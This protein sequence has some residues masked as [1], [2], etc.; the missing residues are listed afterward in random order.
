MK[1]LD[2]SPSATLTLRDEEQEI[3]FSEGEIEDDWY[4][5]ENRIL[6]ETASSIWGKEYLFKHKL[7][8]DV[9]VQK[10]LN[11]FT[12]ARELINPE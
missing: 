4:Y 12:E 2:A 3:I 1:F 11:H 10:A 7:I 9:Q 5:L 8:Q 6:A